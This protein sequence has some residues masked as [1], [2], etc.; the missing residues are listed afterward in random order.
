MKVSKAAVVGVIGRIWI[1]P[2]IAKLEGVA[3]GWITERQ[4]GCPS[5]LDP[6]TSGGEKVGLKNE[7]DARLQQAKTR[8][9]CTKC[10]VVTRGV[11]ENAR[12]QSG[13]HAMSCE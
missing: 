13:A 5:R 1:L 4:M 9:E 6:H 8:R 2:A 11:R 7:D 12:G 10:S 3:F